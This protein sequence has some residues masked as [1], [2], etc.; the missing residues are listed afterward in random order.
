MKGVFSLLIFLLGILP[1]TGQ[2]TI[3][4]NADSDPE[5]RTILE[6]MRNKYEAYSTMDVS[7][8]LDMKLP[9]QAAEKQA[10]RFRKKGEAYRV[11]MGG[12]I[13]ISDGTTLW[14]IMERNQEVQITDVPEVSEDEGILSPESLFRLY[15]RQDFAFFLVGEGMENGKAIQQI[16]FKPLDKEADYSKLRLTLRKGTN[17]FVRVKAFGR[18]GARFTITADKLQT[19]TALADQLFT[20]NKA[21]FPDFYVEDLR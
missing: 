21:E 15:E 6:N 20:F 8:S 4:S 1:L 13:I 16:E 19:N 9:D 17:D 3:S 11:E 10:I 2:N 18:D 7:F 14:L 5:A 12:R